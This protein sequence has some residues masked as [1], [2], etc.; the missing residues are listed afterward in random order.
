MRLGV[1]PGGVSWPAVMVVRDDALAVS[2]MEHAPVSANALAEEGASA[3]LPFGSVV[4]GTVRAGSDIDPVAVFDDIE[5]Y[6][7]RADLAGGSVMGCC[8]G[9]WDRHAVQRWGWWC[10][11]SDGC[12]CWAL[13]GGLER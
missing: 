8:A 9:G 7:R 1:V 10:H 11:Q 5:R 6:P 13:D 12:C 4:A 3:V 2:T